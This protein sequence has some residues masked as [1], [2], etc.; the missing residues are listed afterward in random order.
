MH[1]VCAAAHPLSHTDHRTRLQENTT[2]SHKEAFK[3]AARNWGSA[4]ANPQK[5]PR[6]ESLQ[7]GG[8][9]D[10][11]KEEGEE[12]VDEDEDGEE[13]IV[14]NG[15][16]DGTQLNPEDTIEEIQPPEPDEADAAEPD[17]P[18]TNVDSDVCN[19]Y[20]GGDADAPEE[21]NGQTEMETKVEFDG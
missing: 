19:A 10:I 21:T 17:V 18:E 15:N 8:E 16:A 1:E 11:P 13:G 6:E 14:S 7:I 20:D 5:R 4:E 12:G 9:G 2:L 3:E